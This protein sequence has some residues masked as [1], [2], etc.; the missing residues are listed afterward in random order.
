MMK[1]IAKSNPWK[2]RSPLSK[3]RWNYSVNHVD[4]SIDIWHRKEIVLTIPL[5]G[6]PYDECLKLAKSIVCFPEL[7]SAACAS[8]PYLE[9][10]ANGDLDAETAF[11]A[12]DDAIN[13][14]AGIYMRD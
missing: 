14:A 1:T 11:T 4:Q 13:T 8:M 2:D 12:M 9:S 7:L 5:S 3:E 10:E 6:R